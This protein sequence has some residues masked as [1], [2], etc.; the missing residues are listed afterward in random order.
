MLVQIVPRLP[1][2][3]D[4]LGDYALNLARELHVNFGIESRFIVC[5]PTWIGKDEVEGFSTHQLKDCSAD[6]LKSILLN[7]KPFSA[8][9]LHYVGYGYARRGAPVWLVNGLGRWSKY[10]SDT[11]LLMMFHEISASGPFWTSAFWLSP[12]QRHLAARLAQLSDGCLTNMQI[13]ADI[14]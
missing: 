5:D 3:T 9:L 11:R 14:I 12:L 2:A 13:H 6:S 1:P 4:G 7:L 10:R 8:V